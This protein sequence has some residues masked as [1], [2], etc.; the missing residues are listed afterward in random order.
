M[1]S[2]DYFHNPNA[3]WESVYSLENSQADFSFASNR[4][5]GKND[6]DLVLREPEIGSFIVQMPFCHQTMFAKKE[7]LV[8]I[9]MFNERYKSA[10]DYDIVLRA[11]LGGYKYVEVEAD[12]VT[13]RRG[14]VS[15]INQHR[16]DLEKK[17]IYQQ[18]YYPF[19]K[20]ILIESVVARVMGR[21]CPKELFD[22]ILLIAS[23]DL[24][25][26]MKKA[27]LKS[28]DVER[29]Y[30]FSEEIIREIQQ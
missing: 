4:I 10:A 19:F 21:I 1:N 12:I 3:I 26:N 24:K 15:E 17:E 16:S 28:D 14:G 22:N 29:E 5:L 2:D 13:Y 6:S 11:I 7:M 18:L 8:D 30:Y 25:E 9:G 27:I 20:D 23:E